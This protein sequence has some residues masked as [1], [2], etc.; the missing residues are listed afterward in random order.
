[1]KTIWIYVLLSDCSYL[2]V[3]IRGLFRCGFVSVPVLVSL[4]ILI[5][6]VAPKYIHLETSKL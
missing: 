3:S 6:T 1:M 4:Q 5:L 2:L